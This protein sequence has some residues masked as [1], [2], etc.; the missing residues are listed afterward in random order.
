MSTD[1]VPTAEPE[2]QLGALRAST[3]GQLVQGATQAANELAAVIDSRHLFKTIQ[4][5]RHVLVEGWLTLATMMGCLP[6]EVS[7]ERL[8]DG[9]YIAVVELRRMADG[10]VMSR[11]SAECGGPDERT[12]Q[13]RPPYARRSMAST[14]AT[15]KACRT[16]FAWVVAL[17]GYASTR[18]HHAHRR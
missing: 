3:P 7:N 18:G 8:D 1:L 10:A 14:R 12:W 6:M 9:T 15:S 16:A 17:A 13:S 2:I 5:R 11:A 4:G